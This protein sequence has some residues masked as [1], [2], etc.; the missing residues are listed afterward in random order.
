[1]CRRAVLPLVS[2]RW[3]Q[4]LGDPGPAWANAELLLSNDELPAALAW[5]QHRAS[6]IRRVACRP[7][8]R[9]SRVSVIK[10]CCT[11][12]VYW[13][14]RRYASVRLQREHGC[15]LCAGRSNCVTVYGTRV[16]H[17]GLQS[18]NSSGVGRCQELGTCRA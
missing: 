11:A 12:E 4:L 15:S 6:G 8:Q 5:L 3:A 17:L 18:L 7:M 10:D 2:R 13:R 9:L 16:L 14:I 1:M